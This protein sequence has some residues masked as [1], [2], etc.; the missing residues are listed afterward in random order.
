VLTEIMGS[1]EK[2]TYN[3]YSA[4]LA[5]KIPGCKWFPTFEEVARYVADNAESGDMIITLG[6]GDVYKVAFRIE[7]ILRE[8]YGE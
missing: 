1:R 2:N 5:A 4:D 8:K 6:C 7:E 3:V